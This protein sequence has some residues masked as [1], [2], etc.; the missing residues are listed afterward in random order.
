MRSFAHDS[1]I[2][3]LA[4][5]PDGGQVAS[6]GRDGSLKVWD[7]S[8]GRALAGWSPHTGAINAIAFAPD[9]QSIVTVG[10]DRQA[11]LSHLRGGLQRSNTFSWNHDDIVFG[12]AF[13]PDGNL[14]Y[15]TGREGKINVANALDGHLVTVSHNRSVSKAHPVFSKDGS[16]LLV[17]AGP[18]VMR[19]SVGR[20]GLGTKLPEPLPGAVDP[21]A[22]DHD[23][24]LY[25]EATRLL[26]EWPRV[27]LEQGEAKVK[28]ALAANPGSPLAWIANAHL[29]FQHA[30]LREEEYEPAGL[31]LARRHL[32]HAATLGPKRAEW[33]SM[34]LWL[35]RAEKQ[36]QAAREAS[37]QYNSVAPGDPG[38]ILAE[39]TLDLDD[40]QY[41]KAIVSVTGL[42]RT[43]PL[44]RRLAAAYAALARAYTE[45]GDIDA[46]DAAYRRRIEI[47]PKNPWEHGNYS[48]FLLKAAGD[49]PRAIEEARTALAL[50]NYGVARG[51]LA[52]ALTE[53]A[54][55]TLWEH[56]KVDDAI[57]DYDE[58]IKAYPS[59]IDALYG[60]AAAYRKHSILNHDPRRIAQARAD[61]KV[62]VTTDPKWTDAKRAL[63]EL[64]A[65]EAFAKTKK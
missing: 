32:E 48:H 53:R 4:L 12:V 2:Q 19:F 17:A 55:A 59:A 27:P 18:Y 11:Q 47:D 10:E 5:T 35:S 7:V 63:E 26:A 20:R 31:A 60:R 30:Y 40:E 16:V 13:S 57:H 64:D 22:R 45:L 34:S 50:M 29:A 58:A 39:A 33:W 3:T 21:R 44:G 46:A 54:N 25:L 56:G 14:V 8:D 42:L 1:P 23:H 41:E 38:P 9:G 15:T 6:G 24:E 43:K 36:P 52:D 28:E 61:L 65:V 49:I 37:R 51:C 62:A